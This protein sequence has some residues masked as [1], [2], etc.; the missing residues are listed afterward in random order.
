MERYRPFLFLGLAVVIGLITSVLIYKWL[1]NKTTVK[2]IQVETEAV[3]VAATD[4]MGG[5]VLQKEMVKMAPFLKGSLQQGNYYSDPAGL[6]GKVVMFPIKANEP[7]LKSRLTPEDVS[8]GGVAA[9]ISNDKRAMAIKVDKVIG[10]SGFIHAGNHVD[11]LVTVSKTDKESMPISKIVL[12]DI[13][14]LAAGP[15]MNQGGKNEKPVST[16][17]ITLELSPEQ[18]EKLAHASTQG[19]IQLALRNYKNTDEVA[20]RGVTSASLLS[21]AVLSA[22]PH[23]VRQSKAPAA[24]KPKAVINVEV[25]IGSKKEM[26]NFQREGI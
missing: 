18:A 25:I 16:D 24:D 8:S 5:T 2:T 13:L 17:V 4:I 23:A 12:Q 21:G 15:E 26:K 20:T 3:A 19:K 11:V 7:V 14:V 1:H 10:V 9:I 22:T 6:Q